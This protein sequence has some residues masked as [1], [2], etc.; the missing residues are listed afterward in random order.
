MYDNK[1]ST[2]PNRI[3]SVFQPYVRPIPRGKARNKTEF[4]AKINVSLVN[5]FTIIDR[6][7]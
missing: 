7:N 4:G 6:I 2:Y 5:D 3:V 1:L